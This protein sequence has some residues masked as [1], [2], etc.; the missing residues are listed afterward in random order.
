MWESQDRGPLDFGSKN[1]LPKVHFAVAKTKKERITLQTDT[2]K[3]TV[4]VTQSILYALV[5]P[6]MGGGRT[7]KK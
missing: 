5:S 6:G 1:I 3:Y 2:F 7:R 4:E